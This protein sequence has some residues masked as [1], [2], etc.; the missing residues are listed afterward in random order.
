[1][2]NCM[3][4]GENSKRS[5]KWERRWLLHSWRKLIKS[6]ERTFQM[7]LSKK[8]M[9]LILIKVILLLLMLITILIQVEKEKDFKPRKSK[10][11][12]NHAKSLK[13]PLKLLM[14][15][16]AKSYRRKK[17]NKR[18]IWSKVNGLWL[19]LLKSTLW[20]LLWL[21]FRPKLSFKCLWF[22]KTNNF[23]F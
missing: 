11:S 19:K 18:K 7:T 3:R 22:K 23:L 4:K 20:L 1:M 17:M 16:T 13:R 8:E 10:N 6:K 9:S 5:V 12:T 2:R 21:T 14:K 15:R